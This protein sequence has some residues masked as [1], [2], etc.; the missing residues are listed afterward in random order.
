MQGASNAFTFFVSGYGSPLMFGIGTLENGKFRGTVMCD[1]QTV[2]INC[3]GA[4]SSGGGNL[5]CGSDAY[6]AWGYAQ[7]GCF[8]GGAGCYA[9]V[10]VSGISVSGVTRK[11]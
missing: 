8:G 4:G 6:C 3:G 1:P 9:T 5:W 10:F 2:S 7:P 11:W